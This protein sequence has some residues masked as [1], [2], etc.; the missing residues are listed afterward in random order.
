MQGM[1]WGHM[2]LFLVRNELDTGKLISIDGGNIKGVVR[3][4][5]IARL[6][7]KKKGIMA[8]KLWETFYE[9]NYNL[10]HMES[11]NRA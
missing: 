4:I 3:E 2:P 11:S 5:V 10:N 1:A 8:E 7:E 6:S 9:N